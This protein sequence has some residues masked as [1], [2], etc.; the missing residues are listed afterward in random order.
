MKGESGRGGDG[1]G[2]GENEG[3]RDIEKGDDSEGGWVRIERSVTE[4]ECHMMEKKE[5][6]ERRTNQLKSE[7]KNKNL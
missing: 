6:N 4:M 5:G 1:E 2:G 7:Q 3:E